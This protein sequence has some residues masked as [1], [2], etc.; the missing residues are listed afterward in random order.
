M[1][2][3]YK[4]F[5]LDARAS[6]LGDKTG[7]IPQL[8]IECHDQKGVTVLPINFRIVFKTKTEAISQALASGRRVIDQSVFRPVYKNQKVD[9]I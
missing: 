8:D 7:W 3:K 4:R 2:E 5:Y 9:G 6:E 1:R